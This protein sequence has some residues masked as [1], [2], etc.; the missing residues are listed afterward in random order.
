VNADVAHQLRESRR[1]AAI[2][3][4]RIDHRPLRTCTTG[5]TEDPVH[6]LERWRLRVEERDD[7]ADI[8]RRR[9]ERIVG[10]CPQAERGAGM[11]ELGRVRGEPGQGSGCARRAATSRTLPA[12][13]A[14]A[15]LLSVLSAAVGG[16]VQ[17]AC[18]AAGIA[19][20]LKQV[21]WVRFQEAVPDGPSPRF[22]HV[23]WLADFPDYGNFLHDLYV[24]RFSKH[25]SGARYRDPDV[26]RLLDL[27]RA[28]SD[29]VRRLDIGRRAA[30]EILADKPVLPLFESADYRLLSARVGGFST[31]PVFGVDAWKLWVK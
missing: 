13:L 6:G 17:R 4:R 7:H 14:V 10:S 25:A 18:A 24:Y 11:R 3:Q 8:V 22:L 16:Y 15:L 1:D 27:V 31:D 28:T 12:L 9:R 23:G 2:G 20:R 30:H 29:P 26:T 19:V 5:F 21:S